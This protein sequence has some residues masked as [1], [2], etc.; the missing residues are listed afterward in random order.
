MIIRM[1]DCSQVNIHRTQ[2]RDT[3]RQR[4]IRGLSLHQLFDDE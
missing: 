4:R 1:E 3:E 2:E